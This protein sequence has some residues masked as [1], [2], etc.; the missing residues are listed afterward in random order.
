VPFGANWFFGKGCMADSGEKR[1]FDECQLDSVTQAVGVCEEMVSNYYKLSDSQMLQLN[2]DIRTASR[3]AAH[4]IVDA[5]F[6]QIVRYRARK[7][8]STLKT[9]AEDFYLVCIQDHAI[10]DAI[11]RF[12]A[13][14]LYPFMLYIV[15]HELIHVVRFRRFLQHFHVPQEER[16]FEEIRVHHETRE[17]LRQ[18][19]AQNLDAVL[20]FYGQWREAFE[21]MDEIHVR[22]TP[23]EG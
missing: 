12:P 7:K 5:H 2:Y 17:V 19:R 11:D 9:E 20:T 6:A 18:S 23:P 4:E 21:Q 15:C 8:A 10:L 22:R 14:S 1:K 13:L 3:L 16:Q